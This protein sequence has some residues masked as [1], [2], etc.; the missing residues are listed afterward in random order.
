MASDAPVGGFTFD[1][2]KRNA[3]LEAQMGG[4]ALVRSE[5]V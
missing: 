5:S 1:L 3:F 4:G 2:C